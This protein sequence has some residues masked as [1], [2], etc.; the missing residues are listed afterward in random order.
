MPNVPTRIRSGP[1]Q[2]RQ[3]IAK[4]AADGHVTKQ[5]KARLARAM[6]ADLVAAPNATEGLKQLE[7]NVNALLKE[8]PESGSAPGVGN[9]GEIKVELRRLT[10]TFADAQMMM[11][12]AEEGLFMIAMGLARADGRVTVKETKNVRALAEKM[13]A[14]ADD[15]GATA[16]QLRDLSVM[17]G[18]FYKAE[19]EKHARPHDDQFSKTAGMHYGRM[20]RSLGKALAATEDVADVRQLDPKSSEAWHIRQTLVNLE[21]HGSGVDV[22]SLATVVN[23]ELGKFDS[24]RMRGAAKF[25]L[26]QMKEA[27]QDA[28][29]DYARALGMDEAHPIFQTLHGLIFGQVMSDD[30]FSKYAT[31][32]G[33]AATED[34]QATYDEFLGMKQQL[35]YLTP[36][37]RNQL[38]P[39]Y[40]RF[41]KLLRD[42]LARR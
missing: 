3:T 37:N 31:L 9:L 11:D 5:E 32:I 38:K 27:R 19:G 36:E 2:L 14:Q 41:E 28:V 24:S 35:E 23:M 8:L 20:E 21:E 15:P 22:V 39:A 16:G 7:E 26:D 33:G 10:D 4:A 42:E 13:V 34:V 30:A 12:S 6:L 29:L 25:K 17:L 18:A 1:S 40:G